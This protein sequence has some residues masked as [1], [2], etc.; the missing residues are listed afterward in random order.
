MSSLFKPHEIYLQQMVEV[1]RRLHAVDRILGAKNPVTQDSDLD[2]ECAFLQVRKIVELITFSAI[3]SDERRYQRSRELDAISNPRDKGDY[4]QDWNAA[5]ILSRLSKMSPYFLPRPLGKMTEQ[6]DGVKQ[7][8]EAS[9]KLVHDRLI[10][11]YK[12]AGGFA[13]VPNPYKP[14]G[15]VLEKKKRETARAAIEKEVAYI[16]AAIWEHVKIGLVWDPASGRTQLEQSESAW[17]VSFGDKS[18][19][20][21]QIW[22]ALAV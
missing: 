8:E 15:V 16:K 9:A 12:L 11:I 4:A 22:T 6:T 7:F 21:V 19:A 13:H 3:V 10:A 17:I 2:N 5:D 18:T 1:K 14:N 20:Q